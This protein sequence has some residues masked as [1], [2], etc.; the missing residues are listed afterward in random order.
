MVG[1]VGPIEGDHSDGSTRPAMSMRDL[2][3]TLQLRCFQRGDK[4]R[5]TPFSGMQRLEGWWGCWRA[6][7]HLHARWLQALAVADKG[8]GARLRRR[9]GTLACIEAWEYWPMGLGNGNRRTGEIRDLTSCGGA[10]RAQRRVRVF[11]GAAH[12]KFPAFFS[13]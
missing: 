8:Q 12:S 13:T 2:S 7:F 5:D 11:G 10:G 1:V 6:C 9:V 3:V 4:G